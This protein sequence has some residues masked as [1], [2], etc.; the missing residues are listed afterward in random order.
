MNRSQLPE[1]CCLITFFILL[2][3][4]QD[5]R[6]HW[7]Y[8]LLWHHDKVMSKVRPESACAIQGMKSEPRNKIQA[9]YDFKSAKRN[10]P[11]KRPQTPVLNTTF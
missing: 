10:T 4:T 2:Y 1:F 9:L 3:R 6:I 5:R 8:P 7:L 11:P